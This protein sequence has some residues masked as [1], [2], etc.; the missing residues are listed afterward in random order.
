[1]SR[2]RRHT[3]F[4]RDWSSDV[5][6]SDLVSF[7]VEPDCRYE[8]D[9]TGPPAARLS[10]T[11]TCADFQDTT[12]GTWEAVPGGAPVAAVTVRWDVQTRSEEGRVGTGADQHE[13]TCT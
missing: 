5:C 10:G 4:S 13:Y 6:S 12:A 2:R 11:L 7:R 9:V 8:G 1:L 3:R